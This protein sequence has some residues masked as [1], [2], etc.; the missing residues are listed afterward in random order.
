[1]RIYDLETLERID[2]LAEQRLHHLAGVGALDGIHIP[3]LGDILVGYVVFALMG[4]KPAHCMRTIE[5][6]KPPE[7]STT[8]ERHE[9]VDDRAL[10]VEHGG[11]LAATLGSACDCVHEHPVE[12]LLGIGTGNRDEVVG[13]A[14]PARVLAHGLGLSARNSIILEQHSY[15]S[16]L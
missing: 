16:P 9:V 8:I 15:H 14:I 4:I 13:P 1:M 6:G 10:L 3:C 12:E 5:R 11:V 7:A 2:G